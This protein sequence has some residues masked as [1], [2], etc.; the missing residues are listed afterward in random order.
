MA[1]KEAGAATQAPVAASEAPTSGTATTAAAPVPVH[2]ASPEPHIE[3]AAQAQEQQQREAA[4]PTG[5]TTT[6]APPVQSKTPAATAGSPTLA[7][8]FRSLVHSI[9][10]AP[11]RLYAAL[12]NRETTVQGVKETAKATAPATA[13]ATSAGATTSPSVKAAA[14]E[15]HTAQQGVGAGAQGASTVTEVAD[16]PARTEGEPEVLLK[17]AQQMQELEDRAAAAPVAATSRDV[18]KA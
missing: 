5:T 11:A 9:K 3:A 13:A 6:L 12:T 2:P 1:S 15:Q 18:A 4:A 16:R 17:H 8:R 14:E 10:Q 7:S